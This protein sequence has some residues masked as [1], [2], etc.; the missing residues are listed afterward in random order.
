[1]VKERRR[2][3]EGGRKEGR[4]SLNSIACLSTS[5]AIICTTVKASSNQA[6]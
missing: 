1:M 5:K 2:W 4:E 3:G 6:L